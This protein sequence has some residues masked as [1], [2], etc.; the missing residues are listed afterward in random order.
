M[1]ASLELREYLL[2][3][4]FSIESE[5]LVAE[6]E[7]IYTIISARFLGEKSNLSEYSKKDLFLGKGLFETSP[8]LF[9]KHKASIIKKYEKRLL[10][11]SKSGRTESKDELEKV[12]EILEILAN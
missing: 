2:A 8:D 6:E 7:K 10:G 4:G 1:T 12:K 3:N 11:L 9:E 5:H